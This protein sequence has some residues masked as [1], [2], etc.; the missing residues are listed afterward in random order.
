MLGSG[1]SVFQKEVTLPTL[2]VNDLLEITNNMRD[3]EALKKVGEKIVLKY[4]GLWKKIL[5]MKSN[6]TP[7]AV[8]GSHMNQVDS[9]LNE[10][11]I[12]DLKPQM[13]FMVPDR[14]L[15]IS[16]NLIYRDDEDGYWGHVGG[17]F[18]FVT[19]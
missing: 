17:L 9:L 15:Y 12:S 4:S 11:V 3:I 10:S 13:S 8:S 18:Y 14:E 5:N 1:L 19:K 7:D 16:P 6:K 2:S